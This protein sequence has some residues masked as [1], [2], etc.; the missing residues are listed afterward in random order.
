MSDDGK[1]NIEAITISISCFTGF[2][3]CCLAPV[4]WGMYNRGNT[5]RLPR[6]NGA[7]KSNKLRPAY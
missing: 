7:P 6:T 2:Q 3:P 4:Y 1:F 5:S